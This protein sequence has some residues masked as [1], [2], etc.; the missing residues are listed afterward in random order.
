MGDGACRA[1]GPLRGSE[2]RLVLPYATY[3]ADDG[4][5]YAPG[6]ELRVAEGVAFSGV[7]SLEVHPEKIH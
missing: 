5:R 1:A 6:E 7:I 2:W 3:R 4:A